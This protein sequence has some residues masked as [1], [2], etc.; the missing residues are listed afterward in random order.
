MDN[1]E[2]GKSLTTLLEEMDVPKE[3]MTRPAEEPAEEETTFENPI[4]TEQQSQEDEEP[5]KIINDIP[6]LSELLVGLIDM[7]FSSVAQSIS[8]EEDKEKYRLDQEEKEQS[9]KAWKLYLKHTPDFKMSPS[10]VLI[11][12]I[13]IIYLPKTLTI[14]SDKKENER[15]RQE[16]LIEQRIKEK[17]LENGTTEK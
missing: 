17:D 12:T 1:M 5:A 16:K 9:I 10:T 15:L 11:L 3:E 4:D 13:A 14:M 7:G 2:Y 6:N 8:K